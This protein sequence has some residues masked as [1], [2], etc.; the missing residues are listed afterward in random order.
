MQSK[1]VELNSLL[2]LSYALMICGSFGIRVPSK[3][4]HMVIEMKIPKP[5][6]YYKVFKEGLCLLETSSLENALT[7]YNNI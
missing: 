2:G 5:R 3:K 1:P 6:L 7:A 4:I